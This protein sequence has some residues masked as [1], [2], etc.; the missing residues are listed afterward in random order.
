M[1]CLSPVLAR[2]FLSLLVAGQGFPVAIHGQLA[3]LN[4]DSARGRLL[5]IMCNYQGMRGA[6]LIVVFD[7]YRVQSNDA[8]FHFFWHRLS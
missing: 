2:I 6:H 5:D 1:S 8:S 3:E 4:I 7:A